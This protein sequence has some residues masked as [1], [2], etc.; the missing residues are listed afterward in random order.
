MKKILYLLCLL[1]TFF[2]QMGQAQNATPKDSIYTVQTPLIVNTS[3]LFSTQSIGFQAGIEKYLLQKDIQKLRKSGRIKTIEKDR[4]LALDLGY[5]YQNGLHHNWFLT[6]AYA[7]KRTKSSGF[8]TEFKPMLGV[9]RTFLT[10]ET[11]TVDANGGV[12]LDKLAGNWYVTSGFS[13]GIGKTFKADKNLFFKDIYLKTFLQV[14]YPNFGFIALKP[15][16]QI[17]T[18]FQL[19]HYQKSIKKVIKKGF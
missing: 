16:L 3:A 11:Y 6:A 12:S 15:S 7:M 13:Y 5:Y 14:F 4:F 9:S 10:E 18:S 1:F 2:G 8:F 19:N 17:G